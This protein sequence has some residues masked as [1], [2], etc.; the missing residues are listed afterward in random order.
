MEDLPNQCQYLVKKKNLSIRDSH[1]FQWKP[2]IQTE[3]RDSAGKS[4]YKSRTI[5]SRAR[6][7]MEERAPTPATWVL[8]VNKKSDPAE[9]KHTPTDKTIFVPL[10]LLLALETSRFRMAWLPS[11]QDSVEE[12]F[13]TANAV[14]NV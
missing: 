5:R 14:C 4:R 1:K 12:E 7:L 10:P 6:N 11:S 3:S 2:T 13:G 8:D 9:R